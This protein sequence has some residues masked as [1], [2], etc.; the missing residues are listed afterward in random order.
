MKQ[1]INDL[2]KLDKDPDY[3]LYELKSDPDWYIEETRYRAFDSKKNEMGFK[4]RYLIHHDR[5]NYTYCGE[6]T[7]FLFTLKDAMKKCIELKEELSV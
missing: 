5:T 4:K 2:F 3:I 1:N 7:G 6:Y